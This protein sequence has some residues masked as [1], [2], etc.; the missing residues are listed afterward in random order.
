MGVLLV[1]AGLLGVFVGFVSVIKP[2]RFAGIRTR[3]IG[4]LVAVSGCAL[5]VTGATWPARLTRSQGHERIDEFM[6]AYQFHELHSTRVHA[7]RARVFRAIYEVTPREIRFF[8]TLMA[9]RGLPARLL[10]Q[11]GTRPLMSGYSVRSRTQMEFGAHEFSIGDVVGKKARVEGTRTSIEYEIKKG[12]R[13]AGR[14]QIIRVYKDAIRRVGGSVVSEDSCCSVTLQIGKQGSAIWVEVAAEEGGDRYRLTVVEEG[15]PAETRRILDLFLRSGFLLLAEDTDREL[16]VGAVAQYWKLVSGRLPPRIGNPREF[17]AFDLPD[18]AKV[19]CNFVVEDEGGDWSRVSTET[20]I[21]ATDDSARR[22][23]AVY[24]RLIYPGSATIRR[25]WLDAIKRR[26][27]QD[28]QG[29]ALGPRR[30]NRRRTRAASRRAGR[31]SRR[32]CGP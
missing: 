6:P 1:Y 27:E 20:R 23:F 4:A 31:G 29:E 32:C 28:V 12:A 14:P 10:G 30:V 21:F 7:R 18:F 9:I 15:G 25:M 2:L 5:G 26:A 24:W 19:A 17:L 8:R 3:R 16:V 22:K 13:P 11:G